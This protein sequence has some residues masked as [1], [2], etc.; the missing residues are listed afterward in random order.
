MSQDTKTQDT[1]TTVSRRA[2]ITRAGLAA[3]S[4]GAAVAALRGERAA[5]STV[6]VGRQV[7]GYHETEHVRRAYELARF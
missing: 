7:A 3:G 1:K 4:A 2:F 6:S 5:A